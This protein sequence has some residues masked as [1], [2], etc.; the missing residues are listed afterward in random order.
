MPL[1][2]CWCSR[3]FANLGLRLYG[4]WTFPGL[5]ARELVVRELSRTKVRV[6]LEPW[7]AKKLNHGS[8]T[9]SNLIR[10]P[11][12]SRCADFRNQGWPSLMPQKNF[13]KIHRTWK[14]VNI[15][16]STVPKYSSHVQ[17]LVENSV[18][19]LALKSSQLCPTYS[20]FYFKKI[21]L[22][23]R[24]TISGIIELDR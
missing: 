23:F 4:S 20:F 2:P 21:Q 24:D 16:L 11:V 19:N 22:W 13:N 5:V 10:E 15:D 17:G 8:W 7:F 1:E 18:A 3:T 6:F 12:R 9:S 14:S